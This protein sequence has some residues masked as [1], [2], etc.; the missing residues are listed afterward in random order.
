MSVN[1]VTYVT[2]SLYINLVFASHSSESTAIL[3]G[4]AQYQA[5]S[6]KVSMPRF[7]PCW[8][9]AL[10]HLAT[11][12]NE[13][14]DSSQS[15]L[16]LKFANCFLQQSGQ[17]YYP[18]GD[19]ENIAV[20]LEKV[21]NNAFTAYTNFY[22]HTQNM[23]FFLNSQMWQEIQDETIK[24]LSMNSAKVA[25]EMEVSHGLQKEIASAQHDSLQYQRELAE[26]GSYL[27][28][29][30]EASKTNVR[31][32]LEEFRSSTNEQKDMIFEVFDRVS[33][34][35]NLVVSEVSW[36]YT[37]I[38]YSACILLIY[39]LTATKRTADA[40]LW[41]FLILSFNFGLER[42]VIKYSLLEEDYGRSSFDMAEIV[43]G[44]IWMIRNT[45]IVACFLTLVTLAV[46]YKDLS[47]INNSL[48]EEIKRQNLELK[49]SMENFQVDNKA[50]VQSVNCTKFSKSQQ[51]SIHA[52][53]SE[54]TG[55]KG[56]ELDFSDSDSLD[57]TFDPGSLNSSDEIYVTTPVSRKTIPSNRMEASTSIMNNAL[58]Y[59]EAREFPLVKAPQVSDSDDSRYNL[60]SR[61]TS[62]L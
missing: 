5:L 57:S 12:C 27:S 17:N 22:T 49:M 13:L 28:K 29:A 10:S 46:R 62:R 19:E 1:V 25:E 16:A 56:D 11:T 42:L 45:T 7:G 47:M 3:A 18:C 35:Q 2:L 4:Q 38:F 37:V 6:V 44:R 32:M 48:L 52:L 33:N 21:D 26:N 30:I 61:K 31:L 8:M 54:D 39:L 58:E 14:T 40:R 59:S 41:L 34:L 43:N 24:K 20:C 60:R 9:E 51:P 50:D 36:L 53:L 15:R 23:C 55:F